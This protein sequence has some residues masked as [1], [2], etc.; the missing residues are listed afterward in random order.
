MF[1]PILGVESTRRQYLSAAGG[2]ISLPKPSDA[3]VVAILTGILHVAETL[4]TEDPLAAESI[5]AGYVAEVKPVSPYQ[6]VL[7][8]HFS[9]ANRDIQQVRALRYSM[10]KEVEEIF[11]G[12]YA[13]KREEW[14]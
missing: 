9:D 7:A 14:Q 11:S 3:Q 4:P 5:R 1:C 2:Q 10:A 13:P 12:S 8:S 6:A